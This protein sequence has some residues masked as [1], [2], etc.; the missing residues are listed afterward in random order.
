M[1]TH[2]CGQILLEDLK[3]SRKHDILQ[4][5]EVPDKLKKQLNNLEFDLKCKNFN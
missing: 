1:Q 4:W 3:E 2:L 5:N